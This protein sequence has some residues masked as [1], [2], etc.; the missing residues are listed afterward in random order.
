MLMMRGITTGLLLSLVP[1]LVSG[2]ASD[3]FAV[4]ADK[5]ADGARPVQVHAVD[6]A[7][8]GNVVVSG[9]HG[10][11]HWVAKTAAGDKPVAVQGRA[12]FV[13]STDDADGKQIVVTTGDGDGTMKWVTATAD[14][15][16]G[17]G[18]SDGVQTHVVRLEGS[19]DGD[20]QGGW[21]GVMIEANCTNGACDVKVTKVLDDSPAADAGI[22]SGDVILSVDG[23]DVTGDVGQAVQLIKARKAGDDVNI[24][25]LRGD[26][27]QTVV[28]TLGDRGD[29]PAQQFAFKFDNDGIGQVEDKIVTRGKML[30]RDDDGNWV[31]TDLGDLDNLDDLPANIR[32]L[33]PHAGQRTV[34]VQGDG[35]THTINLSIQHDGESVKIVKRGDDDITVTRTDA[36][37][38]TTEDVYHS[39]NE[40]EKGDPEAAD[41]IESHGNQFQFRVFSNVDGDWGDLGDAFKDGKAFAWKF[42]TDDDGHGAAEWREQLED[43]L[44]GA[45]KSYKDSMTALKKALEELESKDGLSG[46]SKLY[47]IQPFLNGKG[48]SA[49]AFS[50]GKPAYTFEVRPDGQIAATLRKGDTEVVQLFENEDDLANRKPDLYEKYLSVMGND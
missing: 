25:V 43:S 21:L 22:E 30:K 16:D 23:E 17:D 46:L 39:M 20:S 26:T 28:A 34:E 14:G 40:L 11:V 32:M 37:G 9:D 35:D 50:I 42:E 19:S 44:A 36:D 31:V 13:A 10:T 5:V 45:Q 38:N 8:A 2:M 3:V 48:K 12:V 29:M 49:F 18:R 7:Q 1:Y 15:G 6:G 47:E 33:V 27:E 24:V 4:A 41:L